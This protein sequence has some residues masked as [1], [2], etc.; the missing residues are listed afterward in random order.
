MPYIKTNNQVGTV[1]DV[2]GVWD[3][4]KESIFGPA[5]EVGKEIVH[6]KTAPDKPPLEAGV[7]S[8]GWTPVLLAAGVV[9]GA[10]WLMKK[11]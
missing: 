9:L 1:G 3:W 4:L 5:I 6:E 7:P 10:Y 11:K 8:P 2:G